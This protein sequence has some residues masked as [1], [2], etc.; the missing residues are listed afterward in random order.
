MARAL[1]THQT[2]LRFTA[3][4]WTQLQHAAA[5]QDVSVAQYVRDAARQRLNRENTVPPTEGGRRED[6]HAAVLSAEDSSRGTAE[7]SAA[8]WEQGR[9]ARA[10][11]RLLRAQ[12]REGAQRIRLTSLSRHPSAVEDAG[13]VVRGSLEQDRVIRRS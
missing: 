11:A 13:G 10:R 12:A 3:D 6:I 4:Q 9:L 7:G 8:L 1:K 5:S 2:T